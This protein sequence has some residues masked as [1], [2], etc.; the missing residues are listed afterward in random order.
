M[1][2]CVSACS[3]PRLSVPQFFVSVEPQVLTADALLLR[4]RQQH[5]AGEGE[6]GGS[7]KGGGGG[8]GDGGVEP[9][10]SE[11]LVCHNDAKLCLPDTLSL[12]ASPS[13]SA[14]LS[15][16]LRARGYTHVCACENNRYRARS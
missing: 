11:Q 9:P 15:L 10:S 14:C 3:V 6:G 16:T 5:T 12:S 4:F 7:G 1:C 13:H 2:V 8:G